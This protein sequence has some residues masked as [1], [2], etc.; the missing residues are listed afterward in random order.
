MKRIPLSALLLVLPLPLSAQNR[1]FEASDLGFKVSVP[2]AWESHSYAEGTDEVRAWTSPDG[3]LA[4]LIRTVPLPQ[5]VE[6][7]RI[8]GVYEENVLGGSLRLV[9]QDYVL[10]GVTGKMAG[11]RWTFNDIPVV[12][13]AFYAQRPGA[14]Y[15]LSSIIPENMFQ[16]R[17]AETDAIM[18]TFTLVEAV[19]AATAPPKGIG[20]QVTNRQPPPSMGGQVQ[21]APPG[22]APPAAA[23]STAPVA[24]QAPKPARGYVTLVEETARVEFS[25]PE[26]FV[27]GEGRPGQRIWN[28]PAG[29]DDEGV[30]MVVQTVVKSPGDYGNLE[31][32]FLTLL[33]QVRGNAAAREVDLQRP[34][35]KSGMDVV[36]Y[37]FDLDQTVSV[38]RFVYVIAESGNAITMVSFVGPAERA[39]RQEMHAEEAAVSMRLAAGSPPPG[40]SAAAAGAT[41]RGPAGAHLAAG[42]GTS[43]AEAG[44]AAPGYRF[45]GQNMRFRLERPSAWTEVRNTGIT[46]YY[47]FAAPGNGVNASLSV[48]EIPP[49]RE[50]FDEVLAGG[51]DAHVGTVVI[52][53]KEFHAYQSVRNMGPPTNM[54]LRRDWLVWQHGR[55]AYQLAFEG[56]V[57]TWDAVVAPVAQHVLS[58]LQ[59]MAF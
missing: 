32:A 17:T 25:I 29:T 21:N 23:T 56:D 12:V 48:R 36:V 45:W 6:L 3:N 5:Q 38:S 4:L 58:S 2:V 57:R 8:I 34:V 28:G 46:G 44:E 39:Y 13:G 52:N 27:P 59:M 55:N 49:S 47:R 9:L 26:G 30:R 16:A 1:W 10:N 31:E 50:S 7:D 14:F 18:N 35:S 20:G 24:G 33:R 19:A 22:N 15:A 41:L 54:N 11:Y 51:A 40:P 43:R 53:G 42:F 37:A